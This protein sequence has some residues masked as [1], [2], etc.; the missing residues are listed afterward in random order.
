LLSDAA[1]GATSIR[2]SDQ[3]SIAAGNILLIDASEPDLIEFISIASITGAGTTDQPCTV[4]LNHPLAFEHR[5]G[6]LVQRANPQPLGP[7]RQ[8]SVD[9]LPG[10]ACV[11]LN[12]TG[13]LA[14][15]NEVQLSGGAG[16]EYHSVKLFSVSSDGEG[17]YRLPPLSRVA[18]LVIEGKKVVG[19]QTFAA[20]LEFRPDFSKHENTVDLTLSV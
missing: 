17:Y 6:A 10:D 15:A 19:P 12:N 14:A 20:K 7:V 13:G 16:N 5:S 4:T 3:V 2:L 11:F 9:A 1:E 8:I 18:Q